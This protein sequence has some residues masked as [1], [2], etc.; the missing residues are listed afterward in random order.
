MKETNSILI[1][2]LQLSKYNTGVQYYTENLLIA[3]DKLGDEFIYETM[4]DQKCQLINDLENIRFIK[5]RLI[6]NKWKRVFYE[7][8]YIPRYI[9]RCESLLYHSPN[10]IL[11]FGIKIPTVLTVHDLIT[12]DYPYYCQNETVLY[13]KM[14][15]KRSI[16][17]ASKIITVSN[18]VKEDILKH[19]K[20]PNN[21]IEV[22]YHGISSIFVKTLDLSI[23]DKYEIPNKYILFVGNIEPKKNLG[24]LIKAFSLLKMQQGIKHKLVIAGKKGWKYKSVF[25]MVK[26]LG[27]KNEI[28]FTDYIPEKDLPALYS[29]ADIF[30]FPS[31]YE[32]F[33]IP[34]L[35][36]MAC[37]VPV[38]VSNKGALPEVTGSKCLQ[39][40]PY[41]VKHIADKMYKLISDQ[42]LRQKSVND[43]KQWVKQFTWEQTARKTLEVYKQVINE[44]KF[45]Y[46]NSKSIS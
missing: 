43:G 45:N 14:C 4:V 11:P 46:E 5:D 32:G 30:V 21:K 18:Q 42:N 38:L 40:D 29:M 39:V 19:F 15:L 36:A 27:L 13:F 26:E 1:N 2:G 6:S 7:N 17:K 37:E 28:V 22:I 24:R 25:Q 44:S 16:N 9:K 8:I 41:D 12:L 3:I 33:G 34:P 10:Y 31:L 23:I 20:I 35:E